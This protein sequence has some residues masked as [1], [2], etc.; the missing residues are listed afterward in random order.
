MDARLYSFAISNPSI[1]AKLMFAHKGIEPRVVELLP[2]LHPVLLWASGFR[3][4]TVPALKLD[5]R[6]IEG[7]REI[8]RALE[9]AVPEPPLFPA[10]PEQ[11]RAVEEAEAWG[12]SE[13]QDVPRAI[14]R[15]VLA[16]DNGAR[17]AIARDV[18]I[19]LPAV[20]A[21]LNWPVARA[22]AARVGADEARVR[23]VL[24]DLPATLD[25]VDGYIAAGVLGGETPN[26]ADFQIAPS[27]RILTAIDQLAPLLAGRPCADHARRFVP[28]YP[29]T[30]VEIPREVLAA[31]G[32]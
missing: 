32:L 27:I 20:A 23:Q 12:E 25:R 17:T 21:T 6:K 8:A 18:G 28:D 31:A 24:A 13:L 5:G 4:G 26:A 16:R 9:A 22:M 7:S 2:G 19:P 15:Y 30:P 3:R 29:K 1:T 11:R 14:A 10:D